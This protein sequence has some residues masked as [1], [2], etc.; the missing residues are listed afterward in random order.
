MPYKCTACGKF[1][2]EGSEELKDLM[3]DGGCSCGKKFLM[4]VR[5]LRDD[6]IPDEVSVDLG[7]EIAREPEKPEG[8]PEVFDV[9]AGGEK[10][11]DLEFLQRELVKARDSGK[12]VFLGV[13]TIRVLEE[14]KYELDVASLMRGKPVI[15]KTDDGVYY[16]DVPYAMKKK[17]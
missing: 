17:K 15:V 11:V 7:V 8:E 13:E 14:G 3:H 6:E 9:P 1:Y 4:Y 10:E 5:G 2:R 12:P 16:I